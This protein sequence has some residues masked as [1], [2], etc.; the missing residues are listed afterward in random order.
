[1]KKLIASATFTVAL[2][3]ILATVCSTVNA[4]GASPQPGL[5]YEG[6]WHDGY[7]YVIAN[8]TSGDAASECALAAS[9]T[10]VPCLYRVKIEN[11]PD[12]DTYTF[13]GMTITITNSN[14]THFDWSST[15][16]IITIIVKAGNGSNIFHYGVGGATS[17][18]KLY[19]YDNKEISHVT[20]CW[21]VPEQ[22]IP[23]VP[24]GTITATVAIMAAFG[25]Y[26]AL[27]KPKIIRL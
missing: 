24:L 10:G 17:D 15:Q 8:W 13:D 21:G 19:A 23:E 18:T 22:V 7:L 11:P 26:F 16:H 5:I 20:F 2:V 3:L 12:N 6:A 25:A 1:M 9:Y 4:Q 14:G 27:R